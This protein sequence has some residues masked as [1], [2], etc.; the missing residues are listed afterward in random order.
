M[1]DDVGEDDKVETGDDSGD[2]G[3]GQADVSDESDL[4]PGKTGLS[5]GFCATTIFHD[6]FMYLTISSCCGDRVSSSTWLCR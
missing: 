4:L 5:Y 3:D 1:E 6:S 2:E